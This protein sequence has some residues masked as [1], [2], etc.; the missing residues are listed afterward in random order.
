MYV[1]AARS[2]CIVQ[3]G[4]L[5][6][7]LGLLMLMFYNAFSFLLVPHKP[8]KTTGPIGNTALVWHS[9]KLLA[10]NEGSFPFLLRLCA[11]M[12]KSLGDYCFGGKLKNSFT[13]HPKVDTS[14]GEMLTFGY[15][16]ASKLGLPAPQILP[17]CTAVWRPI[18]HTA[19]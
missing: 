3:L 7:G 12:V 8:D 17:A 4:D 18:A 16:C 6:G 10:L 15:S 5:H 1:A 2:A 14:T 9:G 13:A 11:G 19:C